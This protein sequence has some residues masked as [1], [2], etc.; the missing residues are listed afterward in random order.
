NYPEAFER[1]LA[2]HRARGEFGELPFG[3]D[4][5]AEEITLGRQLKR[6]KAGAGT[7]PGRIALLARLLRPMSR[8]PAQMPMLE[9]MGLA[10]PRGFG[11]RWLRRLVVSALSG[12]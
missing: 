9:R 12:R 5:T 8:D 6:L 10:R 3:S 4:L 7:W 2:P 1:A 11:E